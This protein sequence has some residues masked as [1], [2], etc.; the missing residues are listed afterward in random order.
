MTVWG[1]EGSVL[2]IFLKRGE[3]WQSWEKSG[4]ERED[5]AVL[6]ADLLSLIYSITHKVEFVIS[7]SASPVEG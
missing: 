4:V 2:G 3:I 6:S 5:Q 1:Y 7:L